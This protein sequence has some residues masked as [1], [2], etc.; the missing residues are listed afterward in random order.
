MYVRIIDVCFE[1]WLMVNGI[2]DRERK[3]IDM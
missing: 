1:K 2:K 3:Q